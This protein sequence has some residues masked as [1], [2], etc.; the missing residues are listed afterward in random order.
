MAGGRGGEVLLGPGK[1]QRQEGL[2]ALRAGVACSLPN[3]TE[4]GDHLWAVGWTAVFVALLGW[5]LWRRAI[6]QPDSV[7]AMVTTHLAEL[8]EDE[9]SERL[10]DFAVAGVDG[11]EIFPFGLLTHNDVTLPCC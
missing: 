2:E 3:G 10:G 8:V 7:F 9:R 4:R 1:P 11:F 5:W 6:E